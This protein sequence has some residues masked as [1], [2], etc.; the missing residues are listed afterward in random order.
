[1]DALLPGLGLVVGFVS[2]VAAVRL[3]EQHEAHSTRPALVEVR[4]GDRRLRDAWGTAPH[5]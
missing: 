5:K 2:L 3:A 1:M 4:D